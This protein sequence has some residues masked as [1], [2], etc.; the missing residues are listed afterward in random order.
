MIVYFRIIVLFCFQTR[1]IYTVNNDIIIKN[2]NVV[3]LI[4]KNF[5]EY[6]LHT[7]YLIIFIYYYFHVLLGISNPF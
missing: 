1:T 2:I 5:E 7:L 6:F 3:F 4:Q